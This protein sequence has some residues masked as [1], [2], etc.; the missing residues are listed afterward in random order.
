MR[1]QDTH[2]QPCSIARSMSIFGDRWTLLIIRQV[3]MGIRKFSSIQTSL[4]LSKHRLSDR[5]SRLVD[6]GILYKEPY[7]SARRRFQYKLTDKGLELHPI[8]VAIAQWGD[9]WLADEDGKPIEYVHKSC[10]KKAKPMLRCTECN[11]DITAYNTSA[12]PGPGILK[13][14]ARGEFNDTDMQLYG[15]SILNKRLQE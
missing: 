8:I 7:D 12:I 15:E 2:S 5:L 6:E 11:E 9:K 4:G 1:W 3:F 14:I 10:G 13:K